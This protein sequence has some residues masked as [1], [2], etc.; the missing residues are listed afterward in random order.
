MGQGT[1]NKT[2]RRI[3]KIWKNMKLITVIGAVA[4]NNHGYRRF[5]EDIG[6]L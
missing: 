2:L 5:T 6:L 3:V 1:L 4:L